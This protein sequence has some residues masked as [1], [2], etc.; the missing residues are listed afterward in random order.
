MP[1]HRDGLIQFLLRNRGGE[2]LQ[3]FPGVLVS[4]SSDKPPRGVGRERDS[5][6][7]RYGPHPLQGVWD[8]VGPLIGATQEPSQRSGCHELAKSPAEIDPGSQIRSQ[9]N[10]TYW[11]KGRMSQHSGCDEGRWASYLPQRTSWS[12]FGTLPTEDC[13][14]ALSARI[15]KRL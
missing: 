4:A 12:R 13:Q 7:Q 15:T 10:W 11:R 8:P 9:H 1:H 6:D 5:N 3:C 2:S 14:R